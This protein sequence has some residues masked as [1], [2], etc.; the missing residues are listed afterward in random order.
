MIDPKELQI[1]ITGFLEKNASLFMKELWALVVSA[2]EG[3]KLTAAGIEIDA[4]GI[5]KRFVD[6]YVRIAS[7]PPAATLACVARLSVL[8]AAVSRVSLE[9]HFSLTLAGVNMQVETLEKAR[10]Y[11]RQQQEKRDREM[12][13]ARET[14]GR[15]QAEYMRARASLLSTTHYPLSPAMPLHSMLSLPLG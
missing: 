4:S 14:A 13:E 3:G 11:Q 2:S 9:P 6:E 12:A 15:L 5:P 1:N 7:P 10:E 8:A